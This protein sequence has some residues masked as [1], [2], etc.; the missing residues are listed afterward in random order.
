MRDVMLSKALKAWEWGGYGPR[1]RNHQILGDAAGGFILMDN[2]GKFTVS[3]DIALLILV[4][5]GY[6]H[7]ELEMRPK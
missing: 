5:Y 4:L 7:S 1:P 6:I 3:W 2:H